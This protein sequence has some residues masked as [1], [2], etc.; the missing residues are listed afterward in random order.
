MIKDNK[1]LFGYGTIAVS[2]TSFGL[3]FTEIKP[4]QEIGSDCNKGIK[5]GS[6]IET[7]RIDLFLTVGEALTLAQILSQVDHSNSIIKFKDLIFDFTKF[8]RGSINVILKAID[9][10]CDSIFFLM[11]YAC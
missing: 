7:N 11:P 3:K 1:L 10:L 4:P 2:Y 5:D 8:D 6:I 9:K